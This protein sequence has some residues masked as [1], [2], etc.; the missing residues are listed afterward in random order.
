[1]FKWLEKFKKRKWT[2]KYTVEYTMTWTDI[3]S[4]ETITFYLREDEQGNRKY[5]WHCYGFSETFDSYKN[6]EA[7]IKLW[8]QT[9]IVP[10][11]AKNVLAEKLKGNAQC[12]NG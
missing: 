3:N 7:Q 11:H 9:G 6:F 8:Q 2:L 1:M 4:V 10:K 12:L 5:D